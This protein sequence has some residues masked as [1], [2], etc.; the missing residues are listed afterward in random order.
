MTWVLWVGGDMT[1]N[2]WRG[3]RESMIHFNCWKIYFVFPN[4]IFQLQLGGKKKTEKIKILLFN[5]FVFMC[6]QRSLKRK[7]LTTSRFAVEGGYC[8]PKTIV[9][10]W[11]ELERN[12]VFAF[13]TCKVTT[14]AH[15]QQNFYSE[16]GPPPAGSHCCLKKKHTHTHTHNKCTL[17]ASMQGGFLWKAAAHCMRFQLFDWNFRKKKKK[18]ARKLEGLFHI[19]VPSRTRNKKKIPKKFRKNSPLS[20]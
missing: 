18:T 11:F 9:F 7:L 12:Q 10:K 19:F 3:V 20:C 17:L 5:F 14:R 16:I 6:P 15:F 13:N 1:R 8:V 4:K 2:Q